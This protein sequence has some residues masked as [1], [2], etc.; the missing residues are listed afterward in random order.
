MT[1]CMLFDFNILISLIYRS[2]YP[3]TDELVL[4]RTIYT[5][6]V[7]DGSPLFQIVLLGI[8]SKK[9]ESLKQIVQSS[10]PPNH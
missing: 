6:S 4:E 1:K 5:L 10:N 7:N 2:H 8:Q 3:D 9:I